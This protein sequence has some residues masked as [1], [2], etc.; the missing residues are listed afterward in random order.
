MNCDSTTLPGV[1]LFQPQ[2]FRDDRGFFTEN[3]QLERYAS[4]G[5]PERFV[6]DNLSFSRRGVLRGFHYQHPRAQGK[7]ITALRGEIYDVAVDI[8]RGS[9]HFGSWTGAILSEANGRQMYVP[10]GFAHA[11]VVTGED[12]LVLYKCTDYHDP[13]SEGAIRW[14]DPDLAVAWP[15][16]APLISSRDAAAP[17][18]REVPSERLPIWDAAGSGGASGVS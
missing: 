1:L 13:A 9:P 2:V 5:L 17:R 15:L 7:L 8:R 3:W 11:F 14:D 4:A 10:A 18:L 6:Q 16:A 12:A